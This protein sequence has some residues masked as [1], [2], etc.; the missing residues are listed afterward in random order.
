MK[1]HFF[2]FSGAWILSAI[3]ICGMG[4]TRSEKIDQKISGTVEVAP[5][6]QKKIKPDAVLYLI[7]RKDGETS[8]PPIAVKRYTQPFAF[9]ISFELSQQDAMI[10]DTPF[11]GKLTISGRIAQKGSATPIQSGDLVG[12]SQPNPVEVGVKNLKIVLD[13]SQP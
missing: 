13:Q 9:P 7:A 12:K 10:P 8:G 3:L 5:E 1:N 2:R 4:C 11:E 6:L